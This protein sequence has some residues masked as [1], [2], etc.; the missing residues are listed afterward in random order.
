MSKNIVLKS[1]LLN[2]DSSFRTIEPKYI[3][4]TDN[5]K[6]PSNP[7]YFTEGSNEIKIHYPNNTFN[8]GD[9]IIIQNVVGDSMILFN[10][11]FLITQFNY[12]VIE[13]GDLNKV[14]KYKQYTDA[15][16]VNIVI[17]D[18]YNLPNMIENIPINSF[19]GYQQVYLASDIN[20]IPQIIKDTFTDLTRLLFIKLPNNY[21]TSG[22]AIT[23]IEQSFTV[24]STDIS[25]IQLGYINS[26]YPINNYNY[27]SC[28][29][30]TKIPMNEPDYFYISINTL[31]KASSTC[32][33]GG[34][35][36]Q[37]MKILDTIE[38]YPDSNNY[39]IHLKK[40]FNN[41]VNIELISSEFPYIDMLIQTNVNNKLYWRN[42]Q[43][44]SH[45]Y[46]IQIDEGSY[47]LPT[48]ISSIID[49][50]NR[51]P[52]IISTNETPINNIFEIKY[53]TDIQKI[54]LTSFNNVSLPESLSITKVVINNNYYYLLKINNRNNTIKV[55]DSITISDASNV[56]VFGADAFITGN[57]INKS[58]NVYSVDVLGQSY[59]VLLG[60]TSQI[61]L[62]PI[63][64]GVT[65]YGGSN[66]VIKV[67]TMFS[68]LFNYPDTLG[69]ILGFKHVGLSTSVF[70]FMNS[71]S[72]FDNYINSN[73]LNSIGNVDT[74][75]NLMNFSGSYNYMLM[76]LN[77]IELVHNVNL[78][79][80]FGK[81]LL[82]GNQGDYLF[83]TFV[84]Q[85]INTYCSSFP[86]TTLTDLSIHFLYPD[87]SKPNFRNINHSFTLR[88]VEEVI[89]SSDT[90]LNSNHITII[91]TLIK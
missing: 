2:I 49:A 55:G 8:V 69:H 84:I 43:D 15:I 16:F 25:G 44:G 21:N 90:R 26:N 40:N 22:D 39:T 36:V 54:T 65:Y 52:R 41:V 35:N 45:I 1:S 13:Y 37:I 56:S 86:I 82:N 71:I 67:I 53:L 31:Y 30:I 91:D 81:I 47:K 60:T 7:L 29:I 24:S 19:I 85:P 46:S 51:T 34:D 33:A 42:L 73:N 83:N 9:S 88:I 66:I 14:L 61:S 11:F 3:Y 75:N 68:L 20:Y 48:L 79:S 12:L 32:N 59:D 62:T 57:Y 72:N 74:T 87:G 27:Q 63:T 70:P 50:M 28:Q 10:A 5:I 23:K 38:G 89:H 58:F 4:K 80:A 17:Y 6:L 76:Y 18:L 78:P 77:N 64:T